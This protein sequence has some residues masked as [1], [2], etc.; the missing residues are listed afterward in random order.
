MP[1]TREH[2]EICRLLGMPA[3]LVVLT[4][5]DLVDAGTCWSWRSWSSTSSSPAP[6]RRAPHLAVSSV[7]GQG[8]P[9]LAAL[10]AAAVE[11]A[12][13]GDGRTGVDPALRAHR[14]GAVRLPIDRAFHLKGL[15][16]VIT[17]TL[18]A[19]TMHPATRPR[20]AAR[21]AAGARA[22]RA[23]PRPAAGGGGGGRA[24]L[25]PAHRRRARRRDPRLSARAA[26]RLRAHAPPVR[27]LPAAARRPGAARGFVPVRSIS[28]PPRS[29]AACAR[30][31]GTAH[32]G[33]DRMVEIRLSARRS[34]RAR[35]PL[36]RPPPLPAA[37]L[38]GGEVLDPR[39]GAPPRPGAAEAEEKLAGPL[40]E[41]SLLG[42]ERR[43][44]RHRGGAP[45]PPSRSAAGDGG[46][47]PHRPGRLRHAPRGARRPRP[48]AA[49]DRPGCLGT[50]GGA[51]RPGS[52]GI[53]R[54]RRLA[55]GMP[56]AEAVRQILP[57]RSAELAGVYLDWLTRQGHLVVDGDQVNLPGRS[58]SS[59]AR[60]PGCRATCST[61][62]R[63]GLTPPSPGEVRQ[64]ARR[65]AADPRGRPP[66]PGRA[67]EARGLQVTMPPPTIGNGRK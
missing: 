48:R 2:L 14:R 45:R 9:D 56:K 65:Q 37:T 41:P 46:A 66:L 52:P 44:A 39:G 4:K 57:G 29:W 3:G 17:G 25:S 64:A 18:A 26:R 49:L 67:G 24:D 6:L 55:R 28:S 61:L 1:Q 51:G 13:G 20:A 40:E 54:P 5:A 60:S 31:T 15:G 11:A 33:R 22:Q 19:G 35:R 8:V 59:P 36:H 58:A 34:R 32:A 38:G 21:R 42:A 12:G 10:L 23:G 7:T 63:G 47:A 43:R 30:S 62:E 53:L 27:P 50:C 16:V